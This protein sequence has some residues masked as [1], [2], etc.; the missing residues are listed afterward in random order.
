LFRRRPLPF[1]GSGFAAV[2]P[3]HPRQADPLDRDKID[4]QPRGGDL[5]G[6]DEPATPGAERHVTAA[7]LWAEAGEVELRLRDGAPGP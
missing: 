3:L 7:L 2:R 1:P 6:E 5:S 4:I